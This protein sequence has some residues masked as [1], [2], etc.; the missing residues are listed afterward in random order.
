[1]LKL[2]TV[3]LVFAVMLKGSVFA[4]DTLPS[5]SVKDLS[6]KIIISWKNNYGAR[7][8]TINIQR[9]TDSIKN[10]TTIGSV[11]EPMNRENGFVD[12][13]AVDAKMFYRVFVAF[14]GGRYFFSKSSRPVKDTIAKSK[15]T[16]LL[17]EEGSLAEETVKPVV[18]KGFV[19]SKFVYIGKENN[20][21]ISLPDAQVKK[22]TV[23]FF[24]EN[25]NSVFN[26]NKIT[27]PFLIVE[28]VNFLHAGWFYF[29]LY[30][31]NLLKEK[32][33]F[34]IAKEG[35]NLR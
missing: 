27:E 4:Q 21:I 15:E 22:Y 35:K 2:F 3:L 8:S 29:E 18:P 24:D 10:F 34:F 11:L 31:N 16:K 6:N 23:K 30:E 28:K 5:I 25:N 33:K 13:K 12:A 32:H 19:A 20:I 14:E 7:I 26:I 1:M 9:S 17:L